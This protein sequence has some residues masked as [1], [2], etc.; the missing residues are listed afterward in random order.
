MLGP[1]FIVG[2]NEK[3]MR[4]K[5]IKPLS[6]ADQ[7]YAKELIREFDG[8]IRRVVRSHLG[9]DLSSEFED[10][11]QSIYE[12]ICIQLDDF[13]KCGSQEALVV[14]IATRKVWHMQRDWKPTEE[15]TED[16][17]AIESDR[18][19]GNI[20]PASISDTDRA[21]LIAAY[22]NRDTMEE[23]STDWGCPSA[24]LR[25]RLKRARDRLK[26]AVEKST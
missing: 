23:L 18:G 2:G 3:P 9:D 7:V 16:I 1:T 17:L 19:L 11:V 6:K 10:I 25:Q 8:T 5:K 22:E 20:L 14:T 13:K 4:E 15:L 26:K 21:I 24:K 12:T